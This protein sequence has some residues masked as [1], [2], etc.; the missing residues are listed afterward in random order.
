MSRLVMGLGVAIILAALWIAVFPDQLLSVV[1]WESQRGLYIAAGIRIAAGLLLLT[2]APSTR[3][4][5]GL[6]IFGGLVLLVGLGLL[7]FPIDSWAGLIGWFF[8]EHPTAYRVAGG[9]GGVLLGAF[10]VHASL[11]RRTEP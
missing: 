7:F 9:V 6:R 8:G 5:K 11:P 1:D 3:Y 4:P 10:L 2:A